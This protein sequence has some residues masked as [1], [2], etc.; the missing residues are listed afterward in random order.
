MECDSVREA[1]SA[2]L[3]GEDPGLPDSVIQAHLSRCLACRAW[4]ERAHAVT[5]RVRLGGHALDHN[6]APQL[7][8]ACPAP[9][10]PERR[11]Y[12]RPAGLL[13]ASLAQ[14]AITVPL[15]LLGHDYDAGAHAAHELGSFDLALAIAFAVGALRPRLSAGLAWPCGIAA[16]GL[17][18]TA[19]ADLIAGR[20]PGADE[21]Q[22]LI[23]LAGAAL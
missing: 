19:V 7:L 20:A 2:G 11:R 3:D 5:R 15:L 10:R 14:F 18:G 9:R 16:L 6:L 17:A 13:A 21:A 4:Q 8:A 23:A 22:H 1:I 12:A